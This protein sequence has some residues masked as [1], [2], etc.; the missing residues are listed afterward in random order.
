MGVPWD[1][2]FI[3]SYKYD[4]MAIYILIWCIWCY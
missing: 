4:I 1:P 3:F 2:C